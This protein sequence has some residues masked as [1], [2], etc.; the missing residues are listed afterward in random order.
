MQIILLILKMNLLHSLRR[1]ITMN[2]YVINKIVKFLGNPN[3]FVFGIA[4]MIVLVI[5]GTVA[6]RDIGLYQ[7]QQ[8]F[9][10]NWVAWLGFMPVPSGSSLTFFIFRSSGPVSF[11][12][13]E[14]ENNNQQ[15]NIY[16]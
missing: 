2:R 14:L 9:F 13:S 1:L 4:W 15:A 6:Q 8:L 12:Y 7:A 11:G 10:S 5:I 16:T 3:I